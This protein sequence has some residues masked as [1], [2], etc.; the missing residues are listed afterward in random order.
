[1]RTTSSVLLNGLPPI[2]GGPLFVVLFMWLATALGF[3]ILSLLRTRAA[4]FRPH[5]LALIAAS[6]GAGCLQ[7]LPFG[8]HLFGLM[9]PPVVRLSMGLL[10]ALLIPDLFHI[11]RRVTTTLTRFRP[12]LP[13][14]ETAAWMSLI[15]VYFA[16]LLVNSLVLGHTGDDDGY[17]L[18]APRRWLDAGALVYLP[19][20]THTDAPMGFEMLYLIALASWDPVG[21]KLLHYCAGV[22][23]LLA[24]YLSACRLSGRTAGMFAVSLVLFL[25]YPLSEVALLFSNAFN[26]LAV[27]WVTMA[28]VLIWIVWRQ[29]HDNSLL[30][31]G[32]L[33][34]G[35]AGS[36]KFTALSVG[37]AWLVL[38]L[39]TKTWRTIVSSLTFLVRRY[40]VLLAA[41]VLPW[42]FRNWTLTG[43]P[44][45]PMFASV[46][47][48]RDWGPEQARVF[49][50]FFHYYNWGKRYAQLGESNRKEI[51][52]ASAVCMF[53]LF[54]VAIL[55]TG[56][57]EYRRLLAFSAVVFTAAIA[58]IGLYFRFWLPGIMSLCLVLGCLWTQ[59]RF[60]RRWG[61]WSA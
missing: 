12:T 29:S 37:L 2:L 57:E 28:S 48:T 40:G 23:C 3:R 39:E 17:H 22:S 18:M 1:M 8:L 10:A 19:S 14:P 34:A 53:V 50:V 54:A 26:D 51:L 27:C 43:N 15:A 38:V 47:P 42:L 25:P 5:E 21:A 30:R 32:A 55:R 20:Y 33:C 13:S 56:R 46:I 16:I 41:P 36:Y 60:A 4:S 9:T 58:V 52:L 7:Y 45:Y 6:L 44:V 35:L 24:L 59:T 49:G 31:C 61:G 11:A